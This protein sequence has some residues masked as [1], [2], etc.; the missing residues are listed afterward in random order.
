MLKDQGTRTEGEAGV[1]LLAE[2]V[3]AYRASLT[4]YTKEQLPQYWAIT[5][6]NLGNALNEQSVRTGGKE[7]KELMRQAINAYGLAL[8]VRAIDAFPVQW[9][10]TMNSLRIAKK[11]LE[12]MK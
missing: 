3:K 5:Q 12:E 2:A 11:A 9:D 6:N 4:V 1:T 8:E 10:E 7:G